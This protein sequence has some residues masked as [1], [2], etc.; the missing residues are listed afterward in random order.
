MRVLLVRILTLLAM[1]AGLSGCTIT[2]VSSPRSEPTASPQTTPVV[3]RRGSSQSLGDF[4]AVVA[5][6]EPVAEAA[7]RARLPR[8]NCDFRVQVDNRD[9]PPN[10]FQS[11]DPDGRPVITFTTSLMRVMRNRDELAFA[12]A[13]EAAHHIEGHIPTTQRNATLG[14]VAGTLLGSLAGLDSAGVE[15]AQ[16]IGGT[17]G[18]RR[19]SKDFELEA[20]SLGAQIALRAGYDPLVGVQYFARSPDPGDRFLGSHPPNPERIRIVQR[21]VAAAR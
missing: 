16:N 5:R 9:V 18:A 1:A 6:V 10:A 4:R 3:S 12:F 21:T 13:H 11:L 7:C 17:I 8:G 19:Y 15:A 14:V 20:D 2:T